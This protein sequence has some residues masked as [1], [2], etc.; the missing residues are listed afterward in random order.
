MAR[1]KRHHYL[2]AFYL[3]GFCRDGRLWV[4]DRTTGE[5]REQ[6]PINTAVKNRYYEVEFDGGEKNLEVESSILNE[7]ETNA[8][9]VIQKLRCRESVDE[10]ERA[11]LCGFVAL[12]K[13]RTPAFE[14]QH[15][16]AGEAFLK[17][18]FK[19]RFP[20]AKALRDFVEGHPELREALGDEIDYEGQVAFF[21]EERYEVKFH[22]NESI[23]AML[24]MA[25]ELADCYASLDWHVLRPR[26]RHKSF[27]VSDSP[28]V[29]AF[30]APPTMG[31]IGPG[32]MP[33]DSQVFVPLAQDCCL[34]MESGAG[35]ECFE[36]APGDVVRNFNLRQKAA[37]ERFLIA[38]DRA[39]L[40]SLSNACADH[41]VRR[42]F[43]E[44]LDEARD[45]SS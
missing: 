19:N 39:L 5:L 32:Q 12:L 6:T 36:V 16:L 31:T 29:H 23:K 21:Q 34:V 30:K 3:D 1:A 45:A 40:A 38:R 25:Q 24:I 10:L 27:A 11:W 42:T 17:Q 35:A 13:C 18:D 37:A 26:Q 41:L 20:T 43:D 22:R 33:P 2:P 7:F 28:V 14:G 15:N 9:P 44:A 8:A 4:H